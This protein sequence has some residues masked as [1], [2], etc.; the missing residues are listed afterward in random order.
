MKVSE[1]TAIHGLRHTG[2]TARRRCAGAVTSP[3]ARRTPSSQ[4]GRS[5]PQATSMRSREDNASETVRMSVT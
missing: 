4:A 3:H 2:I 5:S 1:P